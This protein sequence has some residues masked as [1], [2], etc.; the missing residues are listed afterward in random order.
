MNLTPG[1]DE[2]LDTLSRTLRILQRRRGHRATSDDVILAGLAASAVNAPRRL[3]DLGTGK[4]T[5]ALLLLRHFPEA[6]CLGLEAFPAS[7]ALALRNAALND[8][9]TRFTPRLGDL[10]NAAHFVDEA[11]FDLITGAPPFMPLGTGVMPRDPQRAA[12]RFELKGGIE[13][14][15][16]TAA[17]ACA[18]DGVVALLM[19]GGSADRTAAAYRAAGL[20][21]HQR[22]AVHP[23]P[24]RPPVYW[25]F[26]GGLEPGPDTLIQWAMRGGT[27]DAWS[28]EYAA[29][30][31]TLDLP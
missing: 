6:T 28:P 16:E 25:I 3:L 22:I 7:H 27:G 2:S 12:G 15:A 9:A 8:L 11:P 24:E 14:Y 20:H 1:P 30:R 26:I 21:I 10:R 31:H 18:P 23:R 5:V 17:A 19:D 13:G 4:G 29:L